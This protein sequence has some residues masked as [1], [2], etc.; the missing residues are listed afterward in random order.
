VATGFVNYAKRND[1]PITVTVVPMLAG[2][3]RPSASITSTS[4]GALIPNP[5]QGK[6]AFGLKIYIN[7]L[8]PLLGFTSFSLDTLSRFTNLKRLVHER[9]GGELSRLAYYVD[10]NTT[11]SEEN[12][13]AWHREQVRVFGTSSCWKAKQDEF[14]SYVGYSGD[15]WEQRSRF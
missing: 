3:R 14:E 10:R 5:A 7:A 2:T 11:P 8:N 13:N 9:G 1:V 6:L 4:R 15:T 12:R